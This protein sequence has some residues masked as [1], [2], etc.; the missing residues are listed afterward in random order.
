MAWDCS[1]YPDEKSQTMVM[2]SNMAYSNRAV[3][4][5]LSPILLIVTYLLSV[6]LF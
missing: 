4:I 5:S 2:P 3:G 6:M 1:A